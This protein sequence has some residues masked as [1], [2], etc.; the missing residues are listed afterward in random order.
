MAS[1]CT[2]PPIRDLRVAVAASLVAF[3]TLAALP[4]IAAAQG[5]MGGG[6]M[7]GMGG[8]GGG[9]GRGGQGMSHTSSAPDVSKHFEE[10]GS[11]KAAL[12]HIDGLTNDQKQSFSDIEHS[13]S[14]PFKSLGAQAQQLVDSAHAAQQRPDRI[15]M[16]SLHVQAKQL[17]D[18]EV[19]AA[20]EILS[21]DAQRTQFDSN[22][23]QIR[24]EEAKH[25]EQMQQQM[26]PGGLP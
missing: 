4:G 18:Q 1:S 19:A 20:R 2:R 3:V 14:K 15:R 17:R 25:E 23:A 26:S 11:L 21:T 16:D 13:Y 8:G 24:E 9:H 5:G 22:I 10:L 12:K 7:G 6:G